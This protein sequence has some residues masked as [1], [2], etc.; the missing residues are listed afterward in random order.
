MAP[1]HFNLAVQLEKM[2]RKAEARSEYAE[3]LTLTEGEKNFAQ[4]RALA[5]DALG[6]SEK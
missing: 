4:E 6:R 1:F 5:K 2:G 3:F